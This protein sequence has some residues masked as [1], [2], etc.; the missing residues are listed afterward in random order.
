MRF[1]H[2]ADPTE[3][4]EIEGAALARD[5]PSVGAAALTRLPDGRYLLGAWWEDGAADPPGRLDL[6]LSATD[7]F[8]D[9]F[10]PEPLRFPFPAVGERKPAYQAISFLAPERAGDGTGA[11]VRL[12]FVGTENTS[13]TSPFTNGANV[14]DLFAIEVDPEALAAGGGA[15]PV[16]EHLL[17]RE[18]RLESEWGNLDAGGGVHV[19]PDGLLS[20]Y[21]CYHWRM[22]DQ[23]RL[24]ELH[25]EPAPRS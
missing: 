6:Y 16:A 20:L 2:V 14:A 7:D 17:T 11:A 5:V 8:R 13:K 3:P 22:N 15:T 25:G 12:Y 21:S 9:G 10:S 19:G 23:F 1:L 18:L 24:T 4:T